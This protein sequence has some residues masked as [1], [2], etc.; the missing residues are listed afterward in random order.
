MTKAE[1]SPFSHII[2]YVLLLCPVLYAIFFRIRFR[3]SAWDPGV[4]DKTT[5]D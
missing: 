3:D 5:D 1:L 4:L 2:L